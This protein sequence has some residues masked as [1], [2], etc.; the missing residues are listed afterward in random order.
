MTQ[1]RESN[2]GIPWIHVAHL[3]G[4]SAR[5][6]LETCRVWHSQFTRVVHP[7]LLWNRPLTITK[8][9]KRFVW[10][11]ARLIDLPLDTREIHVVFEDGNDS[12]DFSRFENLRVLHYVD[13]TV[14]GDLLNATLDILHVHDPQLNETWLLEKFRGSVLCIDQWSLPSYF[15]S[16]TSV[17]VLVVLKVDSQ[18]D[19]SFLPLNLTLLHVPNPS[20]LGPR[21]QS[22][23]RSR[24][25]MQKLYPDFFRTFA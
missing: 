15:S 6:M 10:E 1:H 9:M 25:V 21:G 13:D 5:V 3:L 12:Y 14:Q 2:A 20:K 16:L 22:L 8:F 11:G 7:M 24:D 17:R 4:E 19:D 23:W 18:I